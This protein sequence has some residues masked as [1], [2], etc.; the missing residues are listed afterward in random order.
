MRNRLQQTC[1]SHF[2]PSPSSI[3]TVSSSI[4]TTISKTSRRR[5]VAWPRPPASTRGVRSIGAGAASLSIREE[6]R[7]KEKES[8]KFRER[9]RTAERQGDQKKTYKIPVTHLVQ[10]D[11]NAKTNSASY[12][13]QVIQFRFRYTNL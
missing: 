7:C 9:S 8:T 13:N 6:T 3:L 11:N 1:C 2:P 4:A 5:V 12:I 10:N